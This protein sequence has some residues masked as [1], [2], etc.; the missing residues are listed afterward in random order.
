[1]NVF[2]IRKN[3][4]LFA[5]FLF[6]ADLLFLMTGCLSTKKTASPYRLSFDSSLI[7]AQDCSLE[8]DFTNLSEKEIK[9]FSL[10]L[11]VFDGDGC[12]VFATSQVSF[13]FEKSVLPGEEVSG[14]LEF[15]EDV[16]MEENDF[17]MADY[18][19]A[20]RIE[21]FDGSIWED[22]LGRFSQ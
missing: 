12:P 22:P 16:V 20:E 10:V 8:F 9:S 18:L 19:Y 5:M 21:Y 15:K 6:T 11:N 17:L 13:P 14:M 4:F 7:S 3:L 1:M 2:M